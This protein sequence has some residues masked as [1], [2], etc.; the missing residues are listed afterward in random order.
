MPRLS[1][2]QATVTIGL[3]RWWRWWNHCVSQRTSFFII[4][5]CQCVSLSCFKGYTRCPSDTHHIILIGFIHLRNSCLHDT[6]VSFR[7]LGWMEQCYKY[8]R[9]VDY[10]WSHQ[11]WFWTI[12]DNEEVI[13]W[14]QSTLGA[15]WRLSFPC[16]LCLRLLMAASPGLHTFQGAPQA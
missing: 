3:V 13:I 10:F 11:T 6:A 15:R 8:S 2:V 7:S 14:W 9:A 16:W 4:K 12:I 5:F 1:L